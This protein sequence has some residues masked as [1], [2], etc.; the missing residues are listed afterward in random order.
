MPHFLGEKKKYCI[1][2]TQVKD[3]IW[4][5]LQPISFGNKDEMSQIPH[6]CFFGQF[7]KEA[8]VTTLVV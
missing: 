1:T 7:L 2:Q 5:L 8:T 4:R 3:L 6:L